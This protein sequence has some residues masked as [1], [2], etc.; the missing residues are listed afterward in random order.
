[1]RNILVPVM[2]ALCGL[3]GTAAAQSTAI[4]PSPALGHDI[5]TRWCQSCHVVE[6]GQAT[7]SDTAPSFFDLAR[8]PEVTAERL[9]AFL[10]AP[11]HPMPP[12]ELSRTDIGDLLAYIDS[13]RGTD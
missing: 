1:M 5:A 9:R 10:T 2:L 6:R 4:K 7:A 8:N 11:R 12:L 3:A 13:L